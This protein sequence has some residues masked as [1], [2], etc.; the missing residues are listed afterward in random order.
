M[1]LEGKDSAVVTFEAGNQLCPLCFCFVMSYGQAAIYPN[2]F[3]RGGFPNLTVFGSGKAPLLLKTKPV[4]AN[5][6]RR[7][8]EQFAVLKH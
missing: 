1:R 2:E 4:P 6:T 7:L 5:R 3:L 8:T